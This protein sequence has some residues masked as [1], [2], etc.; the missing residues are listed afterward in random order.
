MVKSQEV[1]IGLRQGTSL[2]MN[3]SYY[4]S[5]AMNLYPQKFTWDKQ[6]FVQVNTKTKWSFETAV[7]HYRT[8]EW[9]VSDKPEEPKYQ[10]VISDNLQLSLTVQ[11][12][13]TYP[14]IG[15]FSPFLS[16]MKTYVGFSLIPVMQLT[17]NKA[18][19]AKNSKVLIMSGFNYMHTL[20]ITKK[21][22]LSSVLTF[23]A[24]KADKQKFNS[25]DITA[26]NRSISYN[27]GL[28]YKL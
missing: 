4:A 15:Y 26:A 17:Q 10:H 3:K 23:R 7:K 27:I 12:D 2:W 24:L 19:G 14:L 20:P 6:V 28:A 22:L 8:R 25:T 1:L 13:V 16:G 9:L 11:Y 21:L 5:N 18:T